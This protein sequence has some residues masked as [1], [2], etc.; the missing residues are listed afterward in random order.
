MGVRLTGSNIVG[1]QVEMYEEGK[2]DKPIHTF[3]SLG[4]A[5]RSVG[6]PAKSFNN[7]VYRRLVI[8]V[9]WKGK[10]MKVFFKEK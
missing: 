2:P 6:H 9:I 4:K 1:T 3:E 8:E 7:I 5:G 10:K